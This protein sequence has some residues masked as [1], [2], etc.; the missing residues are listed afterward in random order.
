MNGPR[1]SY[2]LAMSRPHTHL[3]EVTITIDGW[4]E[5]RLDLLMPSWTPGSYMIR[6]YAR[7]VQ[8]FAVEAGGRPADWRKVA[9]DCWRITTDGAAPLRATFEVYAHDLTVRTCH[10]DAS[11]AFFTP[12]AILPFVGGRRHEP[13]V[14]R[15]EC[16]N[17]W[18][19]FTGLDPLDPCPSGAHMFLARDYDEAADCPVECGPHR[20]LPFDVDGIPHRIVL[21]GRGNENEGRLVDDVC[22]IVEVERDFFGRLP[23]DAYTFIV[24][25]ANGRGG[26]EHR[27]SQVLLVDR[28]T[29][30]PKASYERFLALVSHELFHAWNVKRIRPD[31]LGPFDY[32]GENYTRQLWT[33]EGVTTYY[34]KRFLLAA[35]VVTHERFLEL[36][37]E[38][39]VALESQ[40]GR[41]VQSLE[42]SSFDA[43]IKLYR[44]DENSA[45]SSISY[46][47]KGGLV[48]MLLDLEIL[49]LTQGEKSLDDVVRHLHAAYPP[50]GPG[51]P[52]DGGFLAAVEAVAGEHA[53]AFRLFFDRHVGGTDELDYESAL[54]AVGLRMAWSHKAARNGAAP[55]WVGLALR[56]ENGRT[57][58]AVSRADGPAYAAGIYPGDEL[59]ALDGARIDDGSLAARIGERAPGDA[60]RVTLFRRDELVEVSVLL[61]A[62]PFD[63]LKIVP[64]EAPD[65]AQARLRERWLR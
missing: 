40:P 65:P 52:E 29:F 2:A 25:L 60:V 61:A 14:L 7:H 31:V 39:V 4:N 53:G 23:Y 44:P 22:R 5:P 59:V 26:L 42:Q 1:I 50:D 48:A 49:R 64:V 38:D 45:N 63:V 3:F 6:E 54:G 41:L 24:H 46:Y 12:A 62:A 13:L 37:A 32:R 35:G 17:G 9:K 27:N 21:W 36:I 28:F 18:R 47:L 20:E 57:V 16:P 11:H 15:V 19:S 56:R 10:L 30:E 34:E 33:M 51:F 8:R 43:W 58:V 55:A